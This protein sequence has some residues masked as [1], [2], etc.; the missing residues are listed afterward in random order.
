MQ[1]IPAALSGVIC[2]K[3]E[4]EDSRFDLACK[5]HEY[6][7]PTLKGMQMCLDLRQPTRVETPTKR[8]GAER[9]CFLLDVYIFYSTRCAVIA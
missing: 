5:R 6:L 4:R 2:D 3:R 9:S 1:I 7:K 8:S